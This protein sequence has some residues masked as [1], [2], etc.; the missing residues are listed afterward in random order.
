[1]SALDPLAAAT[2]GGGL[3]IGRG[4]L[5]QLRESLLRDAAPTAFTILQET[6]FA[7]GEGVYQAFCTWLPAQAG[8][9]QPEDLDAGQLSPVL[10][11]FFRSAGW[12]TVSV[13]PLGAAALA[14]DT[15]DWVEA[16]PGSAETPMC[17]FSA[18]MLS[19]FLGR[20]S[21]EPVAV[22]EVECRSRNDARC[23]FVSAA[24]DTLNAAYEQMTQGKTY[25]EA[26]GA[27]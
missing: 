4:A 1:M 27:R 21:G 9:A 26:L 2:N 3:T 8:V 16:E 11:A 13:A 19:D 7:A 20:L 25:E 12:G 6:G 5:R 23:R 17:F 14:V 15:G 24:P 10:S 22:M 18:G